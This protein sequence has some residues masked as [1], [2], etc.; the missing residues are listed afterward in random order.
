VISSFLMSGITDDDEVKSVSTEH[1]FQLA[2]S[3]T[4]NADLT[5]LVDAAMIKSH[6]AATFRRNVTN[7][8]DSLS[9]CLSDAFL[10]AIE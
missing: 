4:D 5:D 1:A 2:S 10:D 7:S 9:N 6:R 3:H 8:S